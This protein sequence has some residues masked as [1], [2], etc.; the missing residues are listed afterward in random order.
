[1]GGKRMAWGWGRGASLGWRCESHAESCATETKRCESQAEPCA[2]E[3]KDVSHRGRPV[4]QELSIML[5][6]IM[7]PRSWASLLTGIMALRSWA[8]LLMGIISLGKIAIMSSTPLQ[9]G[10]RSGGGR[11]HVFLP[12]V[13]IFMQNKETMWNIVLLYKSLRNKKLCE[14]LNYCTKALW[15]KETMWNIELLYKSIKI[16]KKWIRYRKSIKKR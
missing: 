9:Q 10:E 2:T 11:K 15:N 7:A 3:T 13:H 6:G 16:E 5:T 4:Q 14:T 8:S 1:M 12:S